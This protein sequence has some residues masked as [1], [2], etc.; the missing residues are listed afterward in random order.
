MSR[1]PVDSRKI[2]EPRQR[3][4]TAPWLLGTLVLSLLSLLVA[5][6]VFSLYQ[7][8]PTETASDTLLLYALSSLNF[9]AF[10]VF[11]FIFVRSLL[12]LRRERRERRLGS[13]IKT[14]LVVYFI[15]LSLLPIT[16]MA[17]FSFLFLNRSLERWFGKLPEEVMAEARQLQE[18]MV[19]HQTQSAR[20]AANMIALMLRERP[21]LETQSVLAAVIERGNLSAIEIVTPRGEVLLR[22]TAKLSS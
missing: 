14:R 12:K 7:I 19:K 16:A 8:V 10:I 17:V 22:S 5:L 1:E 2:R 13:K 6:Q 21:E 9:I 15:S 18:D 3:R 4:R 11:A 20:D